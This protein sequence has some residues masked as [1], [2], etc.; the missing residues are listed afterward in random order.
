[1]LDAA[2]SRWARG[3]GHSVEEKDSLPGG[4][5]RYK[6]RVGGAAVP[7]TGD[8]QPSHRL[9]LYSNLHCNLSCDYCCVRSSPQAAPDLIDLARVQAYAAEA[10]SLDFRR[11]LVTG[12][13]PFLRP[14][15]DRLVQ[16]CADHLPTT[17][18]TNG[19]LWQGRRREALERLP[20]DRVTLQVSLDS[21]SADAHDSHRGAGSWARAR[22][23]IQLARDLGFRVR[24]ACTTH[25]LA[26][27]QAMQA[28]LAADG[29]PEEDRIVRPVA[30]RGEA[31]EG[32]ALR[33]N[34]LRPELTLRSNAAYWHPVGATD[35]DFLVTRPLG[36]LADAVTKVRT[37]E[38]Q[39]RASAERLS[40]VFHC[41]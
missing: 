33:R 17:L 23:G 28:F 14:D 18:L 22:A 9:W 1:M 32:V 39:D 38:A 25:T 10:P 24:V 15:I 7:D 12:G 20:R 13:E 8:E 29:V 3:A 36:S 16:A 21:P 41:T 5:V 27:A 26:Q 30:L 31:K 4:G 19:M 11:I 34:E 37:M 40:S 35:E 6:L 2:L